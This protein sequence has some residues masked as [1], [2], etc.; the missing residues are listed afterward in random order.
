MLEWL[1]GKKPRTLEDIADDIG[2]VAY[3]FIQRRQRKSL[4][5]LVTQLRDLDY[6]D[7]PEKKQVLQD[8]LLDIASMCESEGWTNHPSYILCK[9]PL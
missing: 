9:Y 5:D 4:L 6:Q 1:L 2:E 3:T 7:A 8:K